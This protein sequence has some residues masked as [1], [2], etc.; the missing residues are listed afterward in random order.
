MPTIVLKLTAL[1]TVSDP[2]LMFEGEA[3]IDEVTI[4]F[5]VS[6]RA[7]VAKL[8]DGPDVVFT[9]AHRTGFSRALWVDMFQEGRHLETAV[10]PGFSAYSEDLD[11]IQDR[12]AA[13]F[14]LEFDFV[15]S[16]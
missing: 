10:D 7:V 3:V 6:E 12:L 1:E 15:E 16:V 11:F 2:G 14:N 5:T 9:F 8:E 4:P 13:L